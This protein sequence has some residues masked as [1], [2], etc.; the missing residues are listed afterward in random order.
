MRI[1]ATLLLS[2]IPAVAAAQAAPPPQIMQDVNT[3]QFGQA[4]VLA[5]AT[6]DP[7]VAKLV[8]FYR[9]LAPGGGTPAEIREF[10]ARNP[11][12]P[13]QGLLALRAQE[14]EGV[15]ATGLP[16]ITPPFLEQV[17]AL[18]KAGDDASAAALWAAQG[19]TAAAAADGA[20]RLMFWPQQERLARALLSEGNA[21]DA[22]AV[23]AA[24]APPP[25]GERAHEQA[26]SR[27][28]LAGF[29]L[30]RFLHQPEQAATWFSDLASASTAVITQGR[31][32]YWL[33]RS[34]T[35]AQATA[36]Y[37]RAAVYTDTYYGQLAAMALGDT[38]AQLAQRILRT[39]EPSYTPA[40]AID[41]A[42]M[43]LPRAAD[44]LVQMGDPRD[45]ATFLDRLG[46]TA[47]D[48]RTRLLAAK[49]ALAFGIPQ[50]AVAIARVA[51]IHGQ[52]LI[53]EGWPIPV[54]ARGAVVPPAVAYG[55]MRQ[56]S[57]FN[58]TAISGAGAM[59][60][61]QLEPAT[62][63]MTARRSGLPDNNLFDPAQN[64]ALGSTYLDGLIKRF[65]GC[66]PLAIAGYNAGPGNVAN[67]L[68]LNGD[69]RL[70]KSAGGADII[71]WIEEIPFSETRNYV[72]RV[73]ESI[74]IYHALLSGSATSPLA[75]WM[76]K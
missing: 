17:E 74:V 71:D 66:L 72:Q 3:R 8:T 64:I 69:P 28:F 20:Q 65:G 18:H 35:G 54:S 44:L 21:K 34:E 24:V 51:G 40:N 46:Q 73:T 41:F 29:L 12:W 68:A 70:G 49:L 23:V 37:R 76:Q 53:R 47:I 50:S 16:E 9:L 2:A 25:D 58:T 67:W 75:P 10:I 45:A 63:R 39:G 43:E 60:L 33:G 6:G 31:A 22:Y 27:D 11:D 1:L 19:K 7:L 14:A 61:M 5:A 36:D 62:A 56:E 26:G 4:A 13:D 52:M 15:P 48:D 38:P 57:S 32:W 30:L 59:G 55:V 42:L